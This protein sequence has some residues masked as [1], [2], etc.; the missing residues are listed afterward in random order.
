MTDASV[1]HVEVVNLREGCGVLDASHWSCSAEVAVALD[2]IKREAE[3]RVNGVGTTGRG[4][5]L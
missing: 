4:G 2:S 5:I 1:K 3:V